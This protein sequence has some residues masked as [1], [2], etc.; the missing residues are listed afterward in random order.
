[1]LKVTIDGHIDPRGTMT[2]YVRHMLQKKHLRIWKH[3][4]SKD[5]RF[6]SL[7]DKLWEKAFQAEFR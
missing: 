3:L 7:M 5:A 1:M 6:R 2:D 4:I